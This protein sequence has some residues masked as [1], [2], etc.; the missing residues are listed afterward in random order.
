M[1]E[2]DIVCDT[3]R[4]GASPQRKVAIL[5]CNKLAEVENM[6]LCDLQAS[7]YN[8]VAGFLPLS[9]TSGSTDS[10]DTGQAPTWISPFASTG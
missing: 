9:F 6:T 5:F 3:G 1:L 10:M 7:V 4:E 2:G 8:T